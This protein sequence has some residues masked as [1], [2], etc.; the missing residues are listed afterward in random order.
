M[1][2]LDAADANA[3]AGTSV[4]EFELRYIAVIGRDKFKAGTSPRY[5][6]LH[7]TRF[8]VQSHGAGQ[9]DARSSFRKKA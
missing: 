6:P 4:I 8:L 2:E 3:K 1:F 9:L 5:L 7:S